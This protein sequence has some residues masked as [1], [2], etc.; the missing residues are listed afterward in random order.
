MTTTVWF[1]SAFHLFFSLF[2]MTDMHFSK[3]RLIVLN[4][5]DLDH[6]CFN[7]IQ[8]RPLSIAAVRTLEDL[9]DGGVGRFEL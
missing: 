3:I 2:I 6:Y 4:K 7:E 8:N 9:P 1:L 5:P